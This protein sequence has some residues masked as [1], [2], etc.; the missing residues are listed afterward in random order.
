MAEKKLSDAPV[1][2]VMVASRYP[3][4]TADQTEGFKYIDEEEAAELTEAQLSVQAVANAEEALR[5][6]EDEDEPRSRELDPKAKKRH[7]RLKGAFE[8]G[9]SAAKGTAPKPAE[10]KDGK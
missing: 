1:D 9:V 8:A 6:D 7:E 4:G 2:V 5:R 10:K 3:D